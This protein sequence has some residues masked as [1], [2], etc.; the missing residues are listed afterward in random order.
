MNIN[1]QMNSSSIFVRMF[2]ADA[3]IGCQ[4]MNRKILGCAVGVCLC[5]ANTKRK[6]KNRRKRI[7]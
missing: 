5:I 6:K 2:N 3:I 7:I 4:K 1:M